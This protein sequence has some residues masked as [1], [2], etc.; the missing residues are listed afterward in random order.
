MAHADED[1]SGS[2]LPSTKQHLHP[3][4]Y[5]AFRGLPELGKQCDDLLRTASQIVLDQP[6]MQTKALLPSS[7]PCP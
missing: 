4:L 5:E 7:K 6:Q 3:R 2:S 1:A